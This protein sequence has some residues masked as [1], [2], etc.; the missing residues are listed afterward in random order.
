MVI[1]AERLITGSCADTVAAD[2]PAAR[3]GGRVAWR[4][5]TLRR[6]VVKAG[7]PQVKSEKQPRNEAQCRSES[8]PIPPNRPPPRAALSSAALSIHRPYQISR[9]VDHQEHDVRAAQSARSRSGS[10][11]HIRR[12]SR[13]AQTGRHQHDRR[14]REREAG[15]AV[16]AE[17]RSRNEQPQARASCAILARRP[18][19][20]V[21]A[22]SRKARTSAHGRGQ[23]LWPHGMNFSVALLAAAAS[24]RA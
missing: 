9:R 22:R 17:S 13:I 3:P 1:G 12:A 10:R 15:S 11:L 14:Q 19:P 8:R 4:F 24:V 5:Y 6:R 16:S 23:S 7:R 21:R 18:A 2:A 20:T